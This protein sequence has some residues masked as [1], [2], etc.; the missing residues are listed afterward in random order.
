MTLSQYLLTTAVH[1][2]SPLLSSLVMAYMGHAVHAGDGIH[3]TSAM[4]SENLASLNSPGPRRHCNHAVLSL[5][6]FVHAIRCLLLDLCCL[7]SVTL[8]V[9]CSP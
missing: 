9:N 1:N 8:V 6:L 4:A 2:S 5:S 3:R 7:E